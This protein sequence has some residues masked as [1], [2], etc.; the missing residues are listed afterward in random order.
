LNIR[1]H[2]AEMLLKNSSLPIADIG[3]SSGFNSVEHFTTAFRLQY[4]TAPSK[5]RMGKTIQ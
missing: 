3:F 5:F 1:L 4:N 2:H